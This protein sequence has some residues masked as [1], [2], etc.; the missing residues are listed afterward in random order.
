MTLDCL[1]AL[2]AGLEGVSAEVWVVD[3]A[4]A[5]GSADAIRAAFLAANL[6]EPDAALVTDAAAAADLSGLGLAEWARRASA[7]A[8]TYFDRTRWATFCGDLHSALSGFRAPTTTSVKPADMGGFWAAIAQA[9]A[10]E[11]RP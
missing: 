8:A 4:S 3:N 7:E 1:H 2:Q 9:N 10:R 6:P 11:V 5:D